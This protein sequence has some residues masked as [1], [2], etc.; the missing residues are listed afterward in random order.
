MYSRYVT[1]N[2]REVSPKEKLANPLG[3]GRSCLEY[4]ED[5]AASG[6][7]VGVGDPDTLKTVGKTLNARVSMTALLP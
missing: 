7:G 6:A 1:G 5:P 2:Q 3:D 4:V